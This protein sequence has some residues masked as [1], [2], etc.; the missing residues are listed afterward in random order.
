MDKYVIWTWFI[1]LSI[2]WWQNFF[3]ALIFN[4]NCFYS[5]EQWMCLISRRAFCIIAKLR[6]S[7]EQVH[8]IFGTDNTKTEKEG[9]ESFYVC[10]S[11]H[12]RELPIYLYLDSGYQGG[13]SKVKVFSAFC[14]ICKKKFCFLI[15]G[16]EQKGGIWEDP[17]ES[18]QIAQL[19]GWVNIYGCC[20]VA[21]ANN[22]KRT[23]ILK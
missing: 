23:F 17:W 14:V 10:I 18:I 13:N 7:W 19:R 4:Q 3:A 21:K 1:T 8:S 15:T 16:S 2:F 12:I 20:Q 9:R 5:H 6:R 11:F 22:R